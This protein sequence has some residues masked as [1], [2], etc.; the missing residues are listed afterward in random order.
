MR[1]KKL[2]LENF[3]GYAFRTEIGIDDFTSIIGRNDVGKSTILHALDIFFN[4]PTKF[5]GDDASVSNKTGA[6]EITCVFDD[7][8][9]NL[10]IDAKSETS[11]SQEFL[12][13]E[14]NFL[15]IV[16][17]YDCKPK[18]PKLGIH[19]RAFH[20][21]TVGATDLLQLKITDLRQRATKLKAD[22]GAVDER[23]SAAIRKAIWD[24]VGELNQQ[25]VLIPLNDE[26]AKKVWEQLQ[27]ELPT[28]AL[29]QTDRSSTDSDSEI[30][31]PMDIAI[32]EA[33]KTVQPKLDE[34]KETVREYAI[35]VAERTRKKLAEMDPDLASRLVPDFKTEPKWQA[36]KLT[37]ADADGIPIN[38]RG[39]GVRRLILINFFRAEAERRQRTDAA[40]G[41]IYA[42]EEPEN[43]Q[44]PSNQKMLIEALLE[45]SRQENSQ[46]IIT[47]HVP[48]I[49]SLLPDESVRF[50]HHNAKKHPVVDEGT[51]GVLRRIADELGILPDRRVQVLVFVEGPNDVA[52]LENMSTLLRTTGSD[53]PD[54]S[55]DVRIAFILSGGGNIKHWVNKNYLAETGIPEVHIYD[56]DTDDPPKYQE[57]VDTVNDRDD[58]SCAMLTDKREMENYLH[59]DAIQS[60]LGVAVK[61]G[62]QDD[63]PTLVAR[64]IH[65]MADGAKPWEEHSEKKTDEKCSR[66]KKR[67]N[68][69]VAVAM[70]IDWLNARDPDKEVAGWFQQIQ[71]RLG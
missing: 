12:L 41:I 53:I 39:S 56:R 11:L 4:P 64:A 60:I 35:E 65:G 8:P 28:F 63:V 69:D 10:V 3:R 37:L 54:V 19:A 42:I 44:H 6:V 32:K 26:D 16:K 46:V 7:L 47:T 50:V 30:T 55:S 52:F 23:S 22:L 34:I 57:F 40:P 2:I 45:L 59:P 20:P 24:H 5:D 66:A 17:T 58:D 14:N 49:T 31:D 13:N 51:E 36:F 48:A 25:T 38:K 71:R 1:L 67:L 18:T 62:D 33:I 21:S 15:E 68:N 61:F 27:K 29:F 9:S 70:T 43:S